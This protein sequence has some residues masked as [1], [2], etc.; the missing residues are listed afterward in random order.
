MGTFELARGGVWRPHQPLTVW[1]YTDAPPE[2]QI[3]QAELW[4]S[5][6]GRG[7]GLPGGRSEHSA[8]FGDD[9]W[10]GGQQ[11]ARLQ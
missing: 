10:G 4:S 3:G 5:A 9:D 7:R 8:A 11:A 2:L 6:R 1:Q